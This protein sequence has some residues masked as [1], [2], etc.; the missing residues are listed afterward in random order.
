MNKILSLF[1]QFIIKN[2][3]IIII[4]ALVLSISTLLGVLFIGNDE[5]T[6]EMTYNNF[7][8]EVDKS[9][10]NEVT[11]LND[12]QIAV[13]VKN[14]NETYLVPNP[15]KENFKEFLLINNITVGAKSKT[16]VNRIFQSIFVLVLIFGTILYV[17]RDNKSKQLI[18]NVNGANKTKLSS[19]TFNDVAG[20]IEA[21]YLV[22]DIIDFIKTPEKYEHIGAKM[23]RGILLYGPPGTG[24]TLLAK[25]IAGE[26][27][28]PFYPMSGSDFVHMYVGVGANRVRELFKKARKSKKAV[29]F[30]DEIDALGKSRGKAASSSN[31]EREQTLNALLTEMSGFNSTNGIIVIAATNRV[32]T[33]D[34]A[35]LRPGRFDRKIEVSLPDKSARKKIIELYLDNKKVSNEVNA[36]K[37]AINTVYFSGAMLENLINE[38]AIIAANNNDEEINIK[39]ID[40]ALYS[41]IAGAEKVERNSNINNEKRI[42]AYH[43]SGHAL[44]SKLLLPENRV[45]KVTIIP[46]TKGAAGFNLNIP[47]DKMFR[48]KKE[49][50]ANIMMLL[51]GRVTEEIVFGKENIT[52]GAANDIQKASMELFEYYSKYG[53]DEQNGLFYLR[54]ES[55]DD[56]IFKNCKEK[57]KELYDRTR[58]LILSNKDVLEEMVSELVKKETLDEDDINEVVK[59][60]V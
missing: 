28:V 1:K 50:E 23:P 29:I 6:K 26:A 20:N 33:L 45:A 11:I 4:V 31:D 19:I 15:Q 38:A 24:K 35:L 37:I 34:E 25:A 48:T 43:E 54:S 8:N 36:E 51:G 5:N 39:H 3:K 47:K 27:N 9:N 12:N 52:T 56:E 16:D 55:K 30:I 49:I 41:V 57:M 58:V 7:L 17:R 59:K 2:K 40:K 60:I 14:N 42:T 22:K 44:I 10:I 53:M 32:D 18:N 21:K 13:K 46:S